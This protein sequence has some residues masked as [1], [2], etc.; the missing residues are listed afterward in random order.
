MQRILE[1]AKTSSTPEPEIQKIVAMGFERHVAQ[2]SLHIAGGD[3]QK[4]LELC[5]SGM[6]FTGPGCPPPKPTRESFICYICGKKHLHDRSLAIHMKSCRKQF[7]AR[8]AKKPE[9]ERRALLE[10][11]ELPEGVTSLMQYYENIENEAPKPKDLISKAQTNSQNKQHHESFEDSRLPCPH[12]LRKFDPTR[13]QF[14]IKCCLHKP[15]KEEAPFKPKARSSIGATSPQFDQH[16]NRVMDDF[17]RQL[18]PC[19]VCCKKFD[20]KALVQHVKTCTKATHDTM[21]NEGHLSNAFRANPRPASMGGSSTPRHRQE[22]PQTSG[23]QSRGG[24]ATPPASYTPKLNGNPAQLAAPPS[25]GGHAFAPGVRR[26]STG[27]IGSQRKSVGGPSP[28]VAPAAP[29]PDVETLATD[30]LTAKGYLVVADDESATKL[31]DKLVAS[32][33]EA[34]FLGAY[35]V[36]CPLQTAVYDA[37]YQTLEGQ[38][39]KKPRQAQLWHGTAWEA[40]PNI[41]QH[42]FN[43]SFAGK[44]GTKLGQAT[45]FSTDLSYSNRFCDRGGGGRDGTKVAILAQVLVGDFCKGESSHVEPPLKNPQTG[46]RFDSTVDDVENPKIFAIF[47]DFQVMPLYLVEYRT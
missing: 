35:E 27:G 30:E 8:E 25:R 33:P 22:R 5:M 4:A 2:I 47:K 16:V 19:P 24:Y 36:P 41:V 13:L 37:L 44:H 10:E 39:G 15:K 11:H 29:K 6:A 23:A 1:A 32:V 3:S 18:Q 9:R 28:S 17:N 26:A 20:K 12:C 42:G 45:Y 43:R 46:E 7:E 34:E 38:K 21:A 40:V 14:H 31:C